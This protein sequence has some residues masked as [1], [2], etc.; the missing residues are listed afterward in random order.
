MVA[1]KALFQQPGQPKN[2]ALGWVELRV[3]SVPSRKAQISL[4]LSVFLTETS[5]TSVFCSFLPTYST[6]RNWSPKTGDWLLGRYEDWPSH[7]ASS[8]VLVPSPIKSDVL[9]CTLIRASLWRL[10]GVRE[11]LGLSF[12][13]LGWNSRNRHQQQLTHEVGGGLANSAPEDEIL[14]QVGDEVEWHA[15]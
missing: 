9:F 12:T 13:N 1:E 5:K 10:S 15:E 4:N 2:H 14:E 3:Q 8:S 6:L 11:G 7:K